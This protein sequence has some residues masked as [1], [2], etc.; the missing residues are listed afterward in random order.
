MFLYP[1]KRVM[2]VRSL[3][4]GFD[5]QRPPVKIAIRVKARTPISSMSLMPL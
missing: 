5:E 2:I 3:N 4:D 1:L